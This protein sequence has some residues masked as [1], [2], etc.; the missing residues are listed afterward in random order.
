MMDN[1]VLVNRETKFFSN[2]FQEVAYN[3]DTVTA[4]L[5]TKR[6]E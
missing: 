3:G 5:V 1:T 2:F 6:K 4:I